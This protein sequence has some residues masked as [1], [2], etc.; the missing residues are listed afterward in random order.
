MGG[1]FRNYSREEGASKEVGVLSILAGYHHTI[2][3]I[4]HYV[5]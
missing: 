2:K 3:S 1:N 4:R 5:R